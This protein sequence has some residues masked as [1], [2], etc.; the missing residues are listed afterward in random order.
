M[1]PTAR[2]STIASALFLVCGLAA[3]AADFSD[4]GAL[5]GP[6]EKGV[7][8]NFVFKPGMRFPLEKGPAYANS[9]IYRPGGYLQKKIAKYKSLPGDQCNSVNYSGPWYDNFCET[10]GYATAMCPKGKGHQGQDIRAATCKPRVVYAVSA[11]NGVVSDIGKYSVT[12]QGESG[13]IYRYLHLDKQSILVSE[14][15]R[16]KRGEKI[17]KVSNEFNGTPTTVHLHFEIKDAVRLNNKTVITFV[18]P[19]TSLVQSYKAMLGGNP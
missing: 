4:P 5:E 7:T 12:I 8:S 15:K 9:Q 16:I 14:D 1:R 17:G 18:P 3:Q 10:R 2:L 6:N 11:E 13:A 19:Y